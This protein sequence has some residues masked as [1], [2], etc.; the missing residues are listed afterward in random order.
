[1]DFYFGVLI[2][3]G[4]FAVLA[5]SYT[6]V[7]GTAGMFTV[8]HAVFFGIGA[9]ASS[10]I[11]LAL[12]AGWM[13]MA[14]A[15]AIAVTA[16]IA[17][18]VGLV[19]LKGRGQGMM[20]ITFSVQIVFTVVLVNTRAVGGEDGVSG[21]PPLG[22]GSLALPPGLP[23]VLFVWGVAVVML[24]LLHLMENSHFGRAIRAIREDEYAVEAT[25]V[26]VFTLKLVTFVLSAAG[27]GLAGALF[28][29]TSSFVSPSSFS[30]DTAIMLITMSV[31]G[32]QYSYIGAIA[33]AVAVT[34]LPL[35]MAALGVPG[36]K[37][38]ALIQLA[39]GVIIILTLYVRPVGLF[40]GRTFR[41]PRSQ[42]P[43]GTAAVTSQGESA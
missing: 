9:Y 12:P 43:R 7:H 37:V 27:A 40:A 38:A 18:V 39:L 1:M 15:L 41:F 34:A 17:V 35:L 3:C 5:M 33:G 16:L 28:A 20:L 30:F 4:I 32:G 14:V 2:T 24:A 13:A 19:A 10:L 36:T 23:T 42:A 8:A 31:L 26:N 6:L 25:G 11:S 29:H 21:V 22:V